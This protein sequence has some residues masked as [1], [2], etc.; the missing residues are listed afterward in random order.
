MCADHAGDNR[1]EPITEALPDDLRA[2]VVDKTAF[3]CGEEDAFV[4]ALDAT[5]RSQVVLVGMETH[6]CVVQTTLGLLAEGRRV[7][8]VYDAVCSRKDADHERALNR[9]CGEGGTVTTSESFMYE[10]LGRAGGEDFK[11]LLAI[12]KE[13]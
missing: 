11:A 12:V 4:Q 7:Q 10:A 5:T 1:I 13:A 2:G 9:I 3:C 8:V 6:I